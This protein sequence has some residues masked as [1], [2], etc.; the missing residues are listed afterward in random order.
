MSHINNPI[1]RVQSSFPPTP[2]SSHRQTNS[3]I[4]LRRVPSQKSVP[5]HFLSLILQ[6]VAY[7]YLASLNYLIPISE[8]PQVMPTHLL[9]V[10][11]LSDYLK[12]NLHLSF[13]LVFFLVLFVVHDSFDRSMMSTNMI[14]G[15]GGHVIRLAYNA[16]YS[17]FYFDFS[18]WLYW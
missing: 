10:L 4:Q 6:Q 18:S 3:D 11:S 15:G 2:T 17:R 14:D 13:D 9:C 12:R 5:L 8:A 1:K 16:A 7:C